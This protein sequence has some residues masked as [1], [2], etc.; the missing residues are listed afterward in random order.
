M[1]SPLLKT[2]D[3]AALDGKSFFPLQTQLVSCS[4]LRHRHNSQWQGAHQQEHNCIFPGR[5]GAQCLSP[6][7]G[8][9]WVIWGLCKHLQEFSWLSQIWDMQKDRRLLPVLLELLVWRGTGCQ[10]FQ[11]TWQICSKTC[12]QHSTEGHPLALVG[13]LQK[14]QWSKHQQPPPIISLSIKVPDTTQVCGARQWGTCT[15]VVPSS[16]K[17]TAK[18]NPHNNLLFS[19]FTLFL[20]QVWIFFWRCWRGSHLPFHKG[21]PHISLQFSTLHFMF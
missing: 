20:L 15:A 16:L 18:F 6:N 4:C 14:R 8:R 7:Q 21:I 5:D 11:R 13:C 19:S 2:W 17:C 10:E 1:L 3:S 9:D 12:A